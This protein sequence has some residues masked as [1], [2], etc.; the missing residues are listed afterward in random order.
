MHEWHVTLTQHAPRPVGL[1]G[2]AHI[3]GRWAPVVVKALDANDA[4]RRAQKTMPG[5]TAVLVE[6]T[7]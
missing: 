1:N 6:R 7:S 4:A 2:A 3:E 5:W